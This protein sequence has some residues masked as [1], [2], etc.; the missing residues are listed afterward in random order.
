M[1]ALSDWDTSRVYF[2]VGMGN[3][4]GIDIADLKAVK[5]ACELIPDEYTKMRIL[6]QLDICDEAFE[7]SKMTRGGNRFTTREQYAGDLTRAITRENA[8][9]FRVWQENY[10][11]ECRNLAQL[12]WCPNYRDE[13]MLRYRYERATG[14]FINAVPGPADTSVASRRVE[15]VQL[16][17]G[18]GF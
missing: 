14:A 18:F 4:T 8:K 15:Y 5:D 17:G 13:Q 3:R 10:L 2:H 6:E 11:A 7:L 12:L 1:V 16:A 9:D